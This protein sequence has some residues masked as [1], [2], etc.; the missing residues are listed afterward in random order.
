MRDWD[1]WWEANAPTMTD[2]Q[3]SRIWQAL[4]LL[5]FYEI[6]EVDLEASD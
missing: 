2:L 6:V 5:R 1:A 3:R 4:D